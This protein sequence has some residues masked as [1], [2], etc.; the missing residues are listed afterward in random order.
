MWK[1]KKA[2]FLLFSLSKTDSKDQWIPD[3][4]P[5]AYLFES[6]EEVRLLSD[7]WQ[8]NYNHLL[9]SFWVTTPVMIRDGLPAAHQ[10]NP[11]IE[12]E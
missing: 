11:M 2:T 8:Y 4:V 10:L 1:N 5:D 7:E 9:P 12:Y 3:D 6:L